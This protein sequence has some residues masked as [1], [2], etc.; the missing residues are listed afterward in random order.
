VTV[1]AADPTLAAAPVSNVFTLQL[2]NVPEFSGRE[3]AE[4]PAGQTVVDTTARTGS[5]Q[6]IVRGGG[7]LV[8]AGANTNTGG[9]KV[10]SGALIVRNASAL[11][12]GTL[13]V[14]AGAAVT[15]DIGFI[16]AT[17][18][19]ISLASGA[20]I[21]LGV[22]GLT[23]AA[24]GTTLD[25]LRSAILLARNGG[26]WNGTSGIGSANVDLTKSKVVG[27][28]QLVSGAFQVAWAAFGDTNLDGRINST[29]VQAINTAKKFGLPTRDSHWSQGDFS[30][31]GRVNST[32]ILQLSPQFGKPSYYTTTASSGTIEAPVASITAQLFAALGGI[33]PD[34]DGKL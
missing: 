27:Y 6:V 11:G 22:S 23:I 18:G 21:D 12:S 29:D 4:V 9:V 32:D 5:R 25:A 33:D 10:E 7:T 16:K 20:K 24:G 8:L 1:S 34:G 31:D 28:R 14:R 3:Y 30:Y 26:A 2:I 15:L 17:V 13:D 19:A